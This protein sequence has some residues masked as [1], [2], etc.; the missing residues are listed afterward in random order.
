MPTVA[1]FM[2]NMYGLENERIAYVKTRC[3]RAQERFC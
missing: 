3:N 2:G 1:F